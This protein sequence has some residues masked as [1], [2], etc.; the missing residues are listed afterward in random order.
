MTR[1]RI[2]LYTAQREKLNE[3]LGLLWR[4]FS[5]RITFFDMREEELDGLQVKPDSNYCRTRRASPDFDKAC[6]RCDARHLS[7]AKERGDVLIYHC[8]HGL[9]EGI[10]PLYDRRG[11]YLGAVVFGQLRDRAKKA[12]GPM[13]ESLRAAYDE[14]PRSTPEEVED[15][16]RLLKWVSE[17]I[18]ENELIRYR[19]QPWAERVEAYVDTNLDKQITLKDL[20]TVVERSPS[21]LS[22]R[23]EKE[24]GTTPLQYV[25]QRKMEKARRLLEEG[26]MARTVAD[27]LAFYDEYHFSKAFKAYWGKPPKHFKRA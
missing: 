12:E 6:R 2:Q 15:I 18:I 5:I 22:H 16:G 27:E 19:N 17:Y 1:G 10:V 21:F 23:F 8:H 13:A 26:A 11:V 24:L 14:L 3:I 25:R 4:L 9:L 20:A 7:L